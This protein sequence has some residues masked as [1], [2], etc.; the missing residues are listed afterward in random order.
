[1]KL[2]SSLFDSNYELN[3]RERVVAL[4]LR[5]EGI[6][7]QP[8]VETKAPLLKLAPLP[9]NR[10]RNPASVVAPTVDRRWP[11]PVRFA[12]IIGCATA[13]WAIIAAPI[14]LIWG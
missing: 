3:K 14:L 1:M 5:R 4:S 7:V 2:I 9:E 12:V 13:C 11:A 8:V 6:P 10:L